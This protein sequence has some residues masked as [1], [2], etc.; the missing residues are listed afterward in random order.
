MDTKKPVRGLAII[1]IIILIVLTA[2]SKVQEP[3]PQPSQVSTFVFDIPETVSGE[4][5]TEPGE[6][7]IPAE[8][9]TQEATPTPEPAPESEP[10]DSSI[11][12]PAAEVVPDERFSS[13]DGPLTIEAYEYIPR[14]QYPEF[15]PVE[16]SYE[17]IMAR[18][19]EF[20]DNKG[21]SVEWTIDLDGSVLTG[22]ETH[23]MESGQVTVVVT[24]D[25]QPFFEVEAGDIS[26]ASNFRGL[27]KWAENWVLEVAHNTLTDQALIVMGEIFINGESQNEALGLDESFDFQLL[28]GKPFFFYSKDGSVGYY[29]DGIL[30]DM[31]LDAVAHYA[32]C[33][34]AMWSPKHFEQ[35]VAFYG[36]IGN[37]SY[38]IEL[39]AFGQTST[40]S[41]PM[42]TIT[43]GEE[44]SQVEE[45]PTAETEISLPE[46]ME[47]EDTLQTPATAGESP[48]DE[49]V[50]LS[51][52]EYNLG[53]L[54]QI[55]ELFIL[56]PLEGNWQQIQ[57]K[58]ADFRIP[59]TEES[60]WVN[61]HMLQAGEYI[62]VYTEL[63]D[64][65]RFGIALTQ[66]G[67][68]V[69]VIETGRVG[70]ASP[71]QNLIVMGEDSWGL[72]LL[73]TVNLSRNP[74]RSELALL[75]DVI[76]D[77]ISQ[78]EIYGFDESF[79]LQLLADKVF[80]FYRRGEEFGYVFDQTMVKL[81]YSD[82]IFRADKENQALN[83]RAYEEMVTFFASRNEQTY[84]VELGNF[85][86]EEET[87]PFSSLRDWEETLSALDL[88]GLEVRETSLEQLVSGR[89]TEDEP[90][91]AAEDRTPQDQIQVSIGEDDYLA[92]SGG[93]GQ[94]GWVSIEKNGLEIASFATGPV[95]EIKALQ[96]LWAVDGQLVL[97][98][99]HSSQYSVNEKVYTRARGDI[100]IDNES[101]N[102]LYGY[103]ESFGFQLLDG[104]AFFFF[105]RDGFFG[106]NFAGVEILLGYTA[107]DHHHT[108]DQARLNPLPLEDKV[109]FFAQRED[110]KFFVEIES[111][112]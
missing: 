69:K 84:Y 46:E 86:P 79:G 15:S 59:T 98:L 5:Q 103:S 37:K 96:G 43:E 66:N 23:D 11:E 54:F 68:I 101:Q 99:A 80:F 35:M 87:Q 55:G 77:Q 4:S 18:R 17:E 27:W 51:L 52:E 105:N 104:K 57:S 85:P 45:E 21:V 28:N 63:G 41:L 56:S 26:P 13:I 9:E 30:T 111:K 36:N 47:G 65:D 6:A 93:E 34:A 61:D 2:C 25:Q 60:I 62:A 95:T 20:R 92:K 42:V 50:S 29:Y 76:I 58:R 31:G 67:D 40:I 10:T 90:E 91:S 102:L 14:D 107:I 110:D 48:V 78:N 12:E 108:G 7:L 88:L 39:G 22:Q 32:C 71:I 106:V 81:D 97:E 53:E 83:P 75:S 38:Y 3:P 24:K 109:A 1:V 33:S 44:A 72:E 8:G 73:R 82:I 94:R 64:A 100:L 19:A 49:A 74:F 112:P 89:D 70:S 16:G